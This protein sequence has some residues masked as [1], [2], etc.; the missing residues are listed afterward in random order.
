MPFFFCSYP[1]VPTQA[2]SRVAFKQKQPDNLLNVQP[3]LASP[4]LCGG[5]IKSC[6]MFIGSYLLSLQHNH[7]QRWQRCVVGLA[8][9]GKGVLRRC[10]FGVHSEE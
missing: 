2:S 9:E 10:V 5:I 4:S 3:Q 8:W 6:Y 1:N 7:A